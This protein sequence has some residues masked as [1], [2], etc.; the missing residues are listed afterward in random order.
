MLCSDGLTAHV[1][2]K[3][4]G[5][6]LR[7]YDD[8]YRATRELV[9]A[10]N[11]GGGTDNVS[12][13]VV[14]A[15]DWTSGNT[16]A[17]S[18]IQRRNEPLNSGT[19]LQNRYEIERLLG[20][21]G[22]GMVYLAH[23]Q[24]L[25]NRPC[26]IKEMVDHFIDQQQRIEAN[27]YFAREADTLAQ[28]KHP[29]IPAITDRFDDRES[30]LP[31][32]G[33]RRGPQPRRG[34]CGAR[35]PAARR[36]DNRHRAPALRRARLPARFDAA[37]GLPRHEAVQRDA[38]AEGASGAGRLRHRTAV[39]ERAQGHHDR[40]A[41]L[42]AARAIPGRGRSAQRHLFAR[43]DAALRAYRARPGKI[44]AVQLS[45]D[46]RPASGGLDQPGGR[47]RS[48]ARLPGRRAAREHP[49]FPRHAALRHGLGESRGRGAARPAAPPGCRRSRSPNRR[50]ADRIR[51]RAAACGAR[52]ALVAFFADPGRRRFRRDLRLLQPAVAAAA[53]RQIVHRQPALEASR[54]G[55]TAP[56][57]IRSISSA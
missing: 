21:G 52:S 31:G 55:W 33:V 56:R 32:D 18:P 48:R 8:P 42:R 26:A 25:A 28:L 53:R 16:L 9:V 40:H 10:A 11:A 19:V 50:A 23:D 24:R 7:R 57:P 41:R 5:E 6:V 17:T 3:T 36:P 27:D 1:D 12:V 45:P 30:P 2:D 13:I 37:D 15:T 38:D 54:S 4:I 35:R 14:F 29:A 20:G 39:Q 43:R 22:M 34:D 47:D 49:G 51:R 44:S 46:A